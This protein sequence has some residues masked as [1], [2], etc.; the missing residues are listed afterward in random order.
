[1]SI[2][3]LFPIFLV[4]FCLIAVFIGPTALSQTE[5]S[6]CLTRSGLSQFTASQFNSN[7][8][9]AQLAADLAK[10]TNNQVKY[11]PAKAQCIA[12]EVKAALTNT[13]CQTAQVKCTAAQAQN[14]AN[15]VKSC[16]TNTSYT[17]AQAQ[18]LANKVKAALTD[19][20]CPA[21]QVKCTPAQGQ[22]IANLVKAC[23]SN[24][25]GAYT[26]NKAL[27]GLTQVKGVSTETP[28]TESQVKGTT[29]TTGNYT[30]YTVVSGDSLWRIAV[31]TQTGISEIIKANPQISNINL[32]YPGQKINI[33]AI[34]SIKTIEN[35]VIRL[36]NVER[37]K[38]GLPALTTNWELS[39][40]ARYKSQ[41]MIDHR[42][43][44]HTSPV[45]GSPFQMM[46]SFGIS[47]RTAGENIAMGQRTAQEV[48]TAWMNSPGH[49]A[50]ILN[51]NFK[52]IGVGYAKS[53]N[54]TIYW[55]QEFIG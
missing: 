14:I 24:T 52:Q 20:S 55:S 7:N 27:C 8:Y 31:K 47:Y 16:L 21:S 1:M 28:S 15:L 32:I 39:R 4:V 45:Y 50:N 37:A 33:P 13:K 23:L 54:G 17:Q 29:T 41:D 22:N 18:C 34:D 35:E 3:K 40:M 26:I 44:D 6:N 10:C 25:S 12:N 2:K 11:T 38:Y 49:R 43:F 46:T 42:Y 9:Q 30:Q 19:T 53:A 36:T 5:P 48:V 51:K